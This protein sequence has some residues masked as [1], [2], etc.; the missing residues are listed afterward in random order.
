[1]SRV[2]VKNVPPLTTK[3]SIHAFVTIFGE[4]VEI[5]FKSDEDVVV[6]F[7]KSEDAEKIIKFVE[8]RGNST[9]ISATPLP[10]RNIV[11]VDR[12]PKDITLTSIRDF[13]VKF[14]DVSE[15]EIERTYFTFQ[16]LKITYVREAD[17]AKCVR[18]VNR[19]MRFRSTDELLISKHYDGQ[20]YKEITNVDEDADDRCVF[21]YNLPKN[22]TDAE[23][24][25]MFSAYGN[26]RSAKVSS[27]SKAFVNYET[28]FAAL[29]AVKYADCV[30]L[31]GSK[32][33]VVI[34]SHKRR[35]VKDD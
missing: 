29:K 2:L 9:D 13:F 21:I 14:G 4:I 7:R 22:F 25:Q 26:I 12:V 6:V 5:D 18:K 8:A 16:T 34:K 17:C 23:L 3:R 11:F 32:I 31:R 28:A 35:K 19:K 10:P 27:N 24:A 33:N 1:M 20:I 15:L 30:V